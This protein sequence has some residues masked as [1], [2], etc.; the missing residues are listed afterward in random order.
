MLTKDDKIFEDKSLADVMADI[1][2]NSKQKHNQINSLIEKLQPLI[3]S[4]GDASIMVPLIKE[5]LDISVK[6]DEQLVKLAQIIQRLIN[7][8]GK[9]SDEELGLTETERAELLGEAK[10]ILKYSN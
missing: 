3:K 5:Y 4:T 1:Y 10:S 8:V 7:A 9:G 6:N 2:T